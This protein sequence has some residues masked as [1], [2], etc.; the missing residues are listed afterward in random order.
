MLY[1]SNDRKAHDPILY[2]RQA[3]VAIRER[4]IESLNSVIW[5]RDSHHRCGPIWSN[6]FSK[7]SAT[8]QTKKQNELYLHR[9]WLSVN[10]FTTLN[11]TAKKD[12]FAVRNQG[13]MAA[14]SL[15]QLLWITAYYRGRGGFIIS[16]RQSGLFDSAAACVD[17]FVQPLRP[18]WVMSSW[19]ACPPASSSVGEVYI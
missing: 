15:G 5:I 18:Q 13:C 16:D 10:C 8:D 12:S 11:K 3:Y 1:V 7:T 4:T 14:F 19:L 17:I 2:T 6:T 9:L